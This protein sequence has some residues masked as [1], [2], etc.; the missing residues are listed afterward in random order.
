MPQDKKH[1]RE[2]LV[3]A[4]KLVFLHHHFVSKNNNKSNK[5]KRIKK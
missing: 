4:E 2:M 3:F 1:E 5:Q